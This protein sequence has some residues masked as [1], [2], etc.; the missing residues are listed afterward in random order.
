MAGRQASG[1]N[2]DLAKS[3]GTHRNASATPQP[4]ALPFRVAI[5]GQ[6][7]AGGRQN[8]RLL[9]SGVSMRGSPL[10]LMALLLASLGVAGASGVA[11]A[12]AGLPR[13]ASITAGA[14]RASL[15]ND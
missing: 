13:I 3:Q 14:H 2:F 8:A 4:A 9:I 15:H 1:A 5:R 11:V 6:T 10:P 7:T 12:G